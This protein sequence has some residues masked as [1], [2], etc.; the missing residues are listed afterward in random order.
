MPSPDRPQTAPA[1]GGGAVVRE[2]IEVTEAER[3]RRMIAGDSDGLAALCDP[4]LDYVHSTGRRDT[5]ADLLELVRSGAVRYSAIEHRLER[6]E[7][8]GGTVWATGTML[9][10]LV[11]DGR[12]K[13]L[14]TLTTT[15]WT[16]D[17]GGYRLLAFHATSAPLV[18]GGTAAGPAGSNQAKRLTQTAG[19]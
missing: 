16:G 6:M 3:L 10:D 1:A 15:L 4:R 12:P 2:A 11:K 9:I 13:R 19:G 17:D 5:L 14:R 18:S 7:P 8:L